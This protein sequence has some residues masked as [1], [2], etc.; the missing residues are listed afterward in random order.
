MRESQRQYLTAGKDYSRLLLSASKIHPT[1][2]SIT[3]EIHA[4]GDNVSVFD[5]K[6][7][8]D[9]YNKLQ[10]KSQILPEYHQVAKELVRAKSTL[11]QAAH[12]L[13]TD[14]LSLSIKRSGLPTK[15]HNLQLSQ[16]VE[17]VNDPKTALLVKIAYATDYIRPE[18][19]EL[20][21]LIER[22]EVLL[23]KG[24]ITGKTKV[25]KVYLRDLAQQ[26]VR[27]INDHH[28]GNKHLD[29]KKVYIGNR[30]GQ[31]DILGLLSHLGDKDHVRELERRVSSSD[32]CL[33]DGSIA[34]LTEKGTRYL[35]LLNEELTALL[36]KRM[37]DKL[38]TLS[39]EATGQDILLTN[40]FDII[41]GYEQK[42]A[43]HRSLSQRLGTDTR[44]DSLVDDYAGDILTITK[45]KDEITAG[46]DRLSRAALDIRKK[47][48]LLSQ[49]GQ[50]KV[51][52]TLPL[53]TALKLLSDYERRLDAKVAHLSGQLK[54]DKHTRP[55]IL[56]TLTDIKEMANLEDQDSIR[57]EIEA[58]ISTTLSKRTKSR[59]ELDQTV[60]EYVSGSPFCAEYRALAS[61]QKAVKDYLIDYLERE[62]RLYHGHETIQ[63]LISEIVEMEVRKQELL[64][65]ISHQVQLAH[66]QVWLAGIKNDNEVYLRQNIKDDTKTHK[67]ALELNDRLIGQVEDDIVTL[68][69][70]YRDEHTR[71]ADDFLEA[72]E[73]LSREVDLRGDIAAVARDLKE[74]YRQMVVSHDTALMELES[75]M[76]RLDRQLGALPEKSR[77]AIEKSLISDIKNRVKI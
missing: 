77:K 55:N 75:D 7:I 6:A 28:F 65:E 42:L 40:I 67:Y 8:T 3:K 20:S 17:L 36:E 21:A 66:K 31:I 73:S 53:L 16:L 47:M 58:N 64:S 35:R 48:I 18:I 37:D 14:Q 52:D 33:R 68:V 32:V 74:K 19:L 71:H 30:S 56:P 11:D 34:A 49:H 41:S 63:T 15:R 13:F 60:R 4:I 61:Q 76:Q 57:G 29:I 59:Q 23:G 5:S 43:K 25:A 50:I 39:Q 9:F 27:R 12:K 44:Y 69:N 62:N 2:L 22:G 70:E 38:L 26:I 1:V 46:I 54:I 51:A 45:S 10:Q 24:D 72:L